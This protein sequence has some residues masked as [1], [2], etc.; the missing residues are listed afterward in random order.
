M[1]LQLY[2]NLHYKNMIN[3]LKKHNLV[4]NLTM[5]GPNQLTFDLEMNSQGLKNEV[6]LTK[7]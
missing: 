1:V 6:T 3:E 7:L 4:R 2:A 5:K